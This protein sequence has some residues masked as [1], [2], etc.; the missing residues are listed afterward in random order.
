M[1]I[2][3]PFLFTIYNITQCCPS[4]P[5]HRSNLCHYYTNRVNRF[6]QQ[7][8]SKV[9]LKLGNGATTCNKMFTLQVAPQRKTT[10]M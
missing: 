10:S 7:P 1:Y 8:N 9:S 6:L 2:G 3:I 4:R 5:P